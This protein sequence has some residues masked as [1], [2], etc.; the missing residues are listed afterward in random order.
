MTGRHENGR[1]AGTPRL[2]VAQAGIRGVPANY[3]GSETAVEEIGR[4]LAGDGLHVVVYCRA[5]KS[6]SRDRDYLGMERVVL[7]S[8]PTLNLDTISHSVLVSL[9]ALL[10]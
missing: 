9:H 6:T 3:G 1:R 5:H 10:R 4:R 2:R 8:I 7:P